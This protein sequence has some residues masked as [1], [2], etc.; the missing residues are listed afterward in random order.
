MAKTAVPNPSSKK[1]SRITLR[2]LMTNE[3]A[4]PAIAK[5]RNDSQ[6]LESF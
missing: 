5:K 4:Y 3:T 6:M 1:P 2:I